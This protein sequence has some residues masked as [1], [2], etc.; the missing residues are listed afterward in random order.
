MRNFMTTVR[1]ATIDDAHILINFQLK[2]AR[3]T[4]RVELDKNAVTQGVT[5]VFCDSSKGSYIV[6]E[7]KKTVV[8]CLLLTYEWS[9]WRNGT[10]WWIQSVYVDPKY[11]SKGVFSQMYAFLKKKVT[12]ADDVLGVRLYVDKNNKRAQKTYK[13]LGMNAEHYLLYEWMNCL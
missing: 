9:D 7:E 13:A 10:V 4:E 2:M 1:Q 3:E 12:D 8:G 6:A 5:R 11:R